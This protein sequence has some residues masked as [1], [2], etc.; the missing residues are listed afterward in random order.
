MPLTDNILRYRLKSSAPFLSRVSC[1][2]ITSIT[3][4]VGLLA[5]MHTVHT[6]LDY[7]A[8][9]KDPVPFMPLETSECYSDGKL[10]ERNY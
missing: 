5:P 7:K 3:M 2:L 1:L 8:S 4:C 10:V 9:C 6:E